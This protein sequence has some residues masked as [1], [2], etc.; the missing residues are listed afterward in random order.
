[1]GIDRQSEDIYT[2]GVLA[3]GASVSSSID[4]LG[5]R[6]WFKI[7]LVVG[8]SY[9]FKVSTEQYSIA[10]IF[11][12]D[13]RGYNIY[14]GETITTDTTGANPVFYKTNVVIPEKNIYNEPLGV[15]G[16]KITCYLGVSF[17]SQGEKTG[18]Y[19]L[20][21]AL[22]LS[23]M[24]T[25]PSYTNAADDF[26]GGSYTDAVLLVGGS[27]DGVINIP[28]DQ[29]WFKVTLTAGHGYRFYAKPNSQMIM[30]LGLFNADGSNTPSPGNISIYPL[31]F[32]NVTELGIF[33]PSVSG[34]YYLAVGV[35]ASYPVNTGGYTV[36]ANDE[37]VSIPAVVQYPTA[38]VANPVE[39]EPP[40]L[41]VQPE[42]LTWVAANQ[43]PGTDPDPD[44][45]PVSES[46]VGEISGSVT[47]V[48]GLPIADAT[49]ILIDRESN[50]V[51]DTVTPMPLNGQYAFVAKTGVKHAVVARRG[52]DQIQ[53]KDWITPNE[54]M[55]PD[56]ANSELFIG[57][58]PTVGV[59]DSIYYPDGMFESTTGIFKGCPTFSSDGLNVYFVTPNVYAIYQFSLSVAY[60]LST[61]ELVGY[62]IY[63][64][65]ATSAPYTN[66]LGGA[67]AFKPDGAK[68]YVYDDFDR[69]VRQFSLS[70]PWDISTMSYDGRLQQVSSWYGVN[71][72]EF[73]PDGTKF[74]ITATF[75]SEGIAQFNLS[76]AWQ[77][78][79]TFEDAYYHA[80]NYTYYSSIYT[81]TSG[82][83]VLG[84]MFSPDGLSVTLFKY[85]TGDNR[86]IA[87]KKTLD[88]AWSFATLN[89]EESA[90]EIFDMPGV[91]RPASWADDGYSI[92]FMDQY[93][94]AIM[95]LTTAYDSTTAYFES[96]SIKYTG[97][98][99]GGPVW[100]SSDGTKLFAGS[101]WGYSLFQFNLS[102]PW[103]LS[104]ATLAY[105]LAMP[106]RVSGLHVSDD[107]LYIF[108][109]DS[110]WGMRVVTLEN[111]FDLSSYYSV[112]Y[113]N[114][115]V[116]HVTSI[117]IDSSLKKLNIIT[118]RY[119]D[120]G[121]YEYNLPLELDFSNKELVNSFLFE[122]Y[123]SAL[124]YLYNRMYYS[125]FTLNGKYAFLVDGID[126]I[127]YI[128]RF[129]V[130]GDIS[131]L[132]LIRKISHRDLPLFESVGVDYNIIMSPDEKYIYFNDYGR[133]VQREIIQ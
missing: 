46:T 101:D 3:V 27:R 94:Y 73:S 133:I 48:K 36:Y 18:G 43:D 126:N 7:E 61:M 25:A 55:I 95:T 110:A 20:S 72:L 58:A 79:R 28:E 120:A 34:T 78:D 108:A 117:F 24:I 91:S 13:D 112:T 5:D 107:G 12:Y 132:V 129:D 90:L 75:Y 41:S 53:V 62:V 50:E 109:T 114:L 124:G 21:A 93:R 74:F 39:Y 96:I 17:T 32:V 102:T 42:Y 83:N 68:A 47:S 59:P 92:I 127:D 67:I 123:F 65:F 9:N 99:N 69:T 88:T 84:F 8:E 14:I 33:Y 45:E 15:S 121:I 113:V 64:T 63:E 38:P 6:D 60:D 130:T 71:K 52:T 80:P 106:S 1:M 103:D 54:T 122:D 89:G 2:D 37:T 70:T 104:T 29:D 77:L 82:Y 16:Q 35:V 66:G 30:A 40:P 4:F 119:G 85:A 115:G 23:G 19:T 49:L 111:P 100:M 31:G 56:L 81:S 51:L 44:P 10:N 125:G 116:Y 118:G 22:T 11:L 105:T 98:L 97:V 87:I 86:T 57:G 26:P 128:F 76:T 131:T